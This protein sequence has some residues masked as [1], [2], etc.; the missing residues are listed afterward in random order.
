MAAGLPAL[1]RHYLGC[2][3]WVEIGDRVCPALRFP[4]S[5]DKALEICL[6]A[7]NRRV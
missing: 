2:L 5:L 3:T 4:N 1:R 7:R 6:A